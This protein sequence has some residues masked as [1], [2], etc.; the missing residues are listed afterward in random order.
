MIL[1]DLKLSYEIINKIAPE[2]LHLQSKEKEMIFKNV[3]NVGGIFLGDY[4][5][6]AFGDYVAGTNHILPTSRSRQNMICPRY[7]ISKCFS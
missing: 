4:S 7:I 6:E 2:H 1:D 3:N 5:T